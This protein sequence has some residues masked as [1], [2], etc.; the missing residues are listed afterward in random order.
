MVYFRLASAMVML[1]Q[2]VEVAGESST[3]SLSALVQW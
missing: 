1:L 2:G 3:T